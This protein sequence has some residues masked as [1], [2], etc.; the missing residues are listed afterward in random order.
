MI[1]NKPLEFIKVGQNKKEVKKLMN[2]PNIEKNLNILS[3]KKFNK[4]LDQLSTKELK[5]LK[6][7]AIEKAEYKTNK[8]IYF[9]MGMIGLVLLKGLI[10]P[11]MEIN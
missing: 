4:S 9:I 7:V 11:L 5:L 10:F 3:Q 2:S 1:K 6:K 8:W